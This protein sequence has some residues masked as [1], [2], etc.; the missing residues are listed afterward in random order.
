MEPEAKGPQHMSDEPTEVTTDAVKNRTRTI[1]YGLLLVAVLAAGI[2][3]GFA[4]AG[5]SESDNGTTANNGS[6]GSITPPGTGTTPPSQNATG[7]AKPNVPAPTGSALV[8]V[9]TPPEGTLAMIDASKLKSDAQYEIVFSPFGY[10][11]PQGGQTLVIRVTKAEAKNESASAMD[12]ANRNMLAVLAAGD[13]VAASGGSYKAK[14]TFR[15]QGDLL[16][17]VIGD[18]EAAK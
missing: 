16:I 18:I 10:G 15:V 9:T 11:P 5:G 14:L 13:D 4:L 12:F 1:L 17:P 3:I 8:T 6:S 2:G 7:S